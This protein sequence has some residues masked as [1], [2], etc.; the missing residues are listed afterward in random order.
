MNRFRFNFVSQERKAVSSYGSPS[1]LLTSAVDNTLTL[2][3]SLCLFSSDHNGIF[4]DNERAKYR[5]SL[6]CSVKIFDASDKNE[7]YSGLG[8]SL[9]YLNSKLIK[10][11]SSGFDN[12][13]ICSN[14][15]LRLTISVD[16]NSGEYRVYPLEDRSLMRSNINPLLINAWNTIL[17]SITKDFIL[18]N[19]EASECLLAIPDFTSSANLNA[20][21]F[22]NLLLE[23]MSLARENSKSSINSFTTVSRAISNLSFNSEGISTLKITSDIGINERNETYKLFEVADE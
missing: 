4:I 11:S 23:R 16:K 13:E 20:C 7:E 12:P 21:A 9:T 22:V 6:V 3:W 5:A 14:L 10:N 19:Q 17:A 2:D 18:E 8:T 15:S 1:N